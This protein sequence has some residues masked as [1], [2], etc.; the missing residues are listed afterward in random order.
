MTSLLQSKL[1][2]V[3]A[4]YNSIGDLLA[5][6]TPGV[7]L[8]RDL[9]DRE[10]NAHL[11]KLLPVVG[12]YLSV[13]PEAEADTRMLQQALES[14]LHTPRLPVGIVRLDG[15]ANAVSALHQIGGMETM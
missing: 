9:E 14:K 3:Y 6:R 13:L 8:L 1:A 12:K 15:A 5:A 10:Q 4:G 2:L 11:E 7:A